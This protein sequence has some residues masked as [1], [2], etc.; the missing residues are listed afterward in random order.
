MLLGLIE[1]NLI[2]LLIL[3][4]FQLTHDVLLPDLNDL[5]VEALALFL[6]ILIL[7]DGAQIKVAGTELNGFRTKLLA[8]KVDAFSQLFD[9]VLIPLL[10]CKQPPEC[11]MQTGPIKL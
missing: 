5:L 11:F 7:E 2:C 4:F 9:C 3:F 6:L 1:V 10:S 8:F